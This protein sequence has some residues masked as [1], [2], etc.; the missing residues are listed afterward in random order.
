MSVS[1]RAAYSYSMDAPNFYDWMVYSIQPYVGG[2]APNTT[3][4]SFNYPTNIMGIMVCP[5]N[6]HFNTSQDPA[7]FSYE[8]VE[9]G[10]S[11]S[12]SRYCRLPWNPFGYNGAAGSGT[13]LPPRKMADVASANPIAQTWAMVDSDQEGNDGAG[14]AP[15]FPPVPAHGATRNYLWFDWHVEPVKVPPASAG[16][17]GTHKN[18]YVYWEEN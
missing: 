16:D 11:T 2:P 4:G 14:S 12:A 13:Q 1:Q 7:F 10:A 6:A 9:G 15:S 5:S 3:G 17:G 18:P 8:M